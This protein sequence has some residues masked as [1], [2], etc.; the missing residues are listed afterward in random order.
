MNALAQPPRCVI[1]D[2]KTYN[3]ELPDSLHKLDPQQFASF[4]MSL[5]R[6]WDAAAGVRDAKRRGDCGRTCIYKGN[7]L[8]RDDEPS[9]ITQVANVPICDAH[10]IALTNLPDNGVLVGRIT[11]SSGEHGDAQFNVA[12]GD[13]GGAS[14][15]RL[16]DHFVV[17]SSHEGVLDHENFAK[18]RLVALIGRP[19]EVTELVVVD[20]G[21]YRV[22]YPFHGSYAVPLASFRT[23]AEASTIHRLSTNRRMLAQF[24]RIGDQRVTDRSQA[25]FARLIR[26]DIGLFE[27]L[28]PVIDSLFIESQRNKDD[29][30]AATVTSGPA[31][32]S[33]PHSPTGF[34]AM[35]LEELLLRYGELHP[36]ASAWY[37]CA[38]GCCSVDPV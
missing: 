5:E 8:K 6:G 10:K 9:K 33:P 11:Y 7:R 37:T 14:P 32:R 13:G 19:N 18:W 20:S 34:D 2:G 25:L 16:D 22:C 24:A 26:G 21:L 27:Q 12:R 30:D 1:E 29:A 23:C 35:E 36:D 17:L 28:R 3:G 38:S 15:R 31:L 4:A